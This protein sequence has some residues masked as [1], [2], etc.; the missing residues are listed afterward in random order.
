MSRH[1][2]SPNLIDRA[3]EHGKKF[4]AAGTL[5]TIGALGLAGCASNAEAKPGPSVSSSAEASPSATPEAPSPTASEVNNQPSGI[6]VDVTSFDD[7]DDKP[8]S[9][10]PVA[11]YD[12]PNS[13]EWTCEQVF[14]ANGLPGRK[15]I[16]PQ[17]G[18]DGRQISDWFGPRFDLAWKLNL[19]KTNPKYAEVADKLLQC[20]TSQHLGTESNGS[21]ITST[22]DAYT[23]LKNLMA[24]AREEG[25]TVQSNPLHDLSTITR[26]TDGGAWT[27]GSYNEFSVEYQMKNRYDESIKP[28]VTYEFT[29]MSDYRMVGLYNMTPGVN[30][31][32]KFNK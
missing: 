10:T 17:G 27:N 32:V 7:W 12:T 2:A 11:A 19:D 23:I 20:L 5:I 16:I 31:D 4:I 26:Q 30:S 15:E 13:K 22:N 21:G 9:L 18:W 29:K 25:S 1:E 3:K 28:I 8:T 14:T 24:S 6:V